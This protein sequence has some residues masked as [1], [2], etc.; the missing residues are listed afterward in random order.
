MSHPCEP[1]DLERAR[2]F[3]EGAKKF[4]RDALEV[5]EEKIAIEFAAA[6]SRIE[7]AVRDARLE[8]ARQWNQFHYAG[9]VNGD[10]YWNHHRLA[11]LICTEEQGHD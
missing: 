9:E 7:H 10:I 11:E 2:E 4:G 8:E 1:Q 6:R 5:L 3:I